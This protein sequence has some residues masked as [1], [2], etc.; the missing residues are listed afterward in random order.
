[1]LVAR[2]CVCM[3]ACVCVLCGCVCVCVMTVWRTGN[4]SVQTP[5]PNV[6]V[7]VRSK[8]VTN[9]MAMKTLDWMS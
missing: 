1:M 7:Q 8:A 3:H 2:V 6:I 4:K 9:W 5:N